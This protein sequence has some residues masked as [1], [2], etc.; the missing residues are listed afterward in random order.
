[1]GKNFVTYK[2]RHPCQ[3]LFF[4]KVADQLYLKKKTFRHL[5]NFFRANILRTPIFTD[6]KIIYFVFFCSKVILCQVRWQAT[7]VSIKVGILR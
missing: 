5:V 3:F 4:N 7:P 1:M 2:G 6:L